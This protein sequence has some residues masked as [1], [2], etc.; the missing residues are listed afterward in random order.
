MINNLFPHFYTLYLVQ[1]N[2]RGEDRSRFHE[3]ATI[4]FGFKP[5]PLEVGLRR[6]VN[7]YL[8]AKGKVLAK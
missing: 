2:R 6:E 1:K 5:M 3:H 8:K 4:D 7:L